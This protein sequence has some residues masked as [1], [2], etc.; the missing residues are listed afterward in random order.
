MPQ[1]RV[2]FR[3]IEPG[4]WSI[5]LDTH[6]GAVLGGG[7]LGHENG[8]HTVAEANPNL[9]VLLVSLQEHIPDDELEHGFRTVG[10]A[11]SIP[12]LASSSTTVF[13]LNKVSSGRCS[14]QKISKCRKQPGSSSDCTFFLIE[15]SYPYEGNASR[16]S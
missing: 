3:Q 10:A 12:N 6:Q 13:M 14:P 5:I 11:Q 2:D 15:P 8:L 9:I 7:G 4:T 1:V 16:K